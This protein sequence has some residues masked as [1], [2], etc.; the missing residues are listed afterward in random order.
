MLASKLSFPIPPTTSSSARTDKHFVC[1]VEHRVVHAKS[2]R[3][4]CSS[5]ALP[6]F[7]VK[8]CL[9]IIAPQLDGALPRFFSVALS[10]CSFSFRYFKWGAKALSGWTY[11]LR[12]FSYQPLWQSLDAETSRKVRLA[13]YERLF[14]EARGKVRSWESIHPAASSSH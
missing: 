6:L 11:A 7:I 9:G 1:F 10:Y 2:H 13:N 8:W 5:R 4:W 12:V 3:G 14:D